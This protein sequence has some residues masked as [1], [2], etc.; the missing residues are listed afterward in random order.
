[1]MSVSIN[2]YLDSIN[3][4]TAAAQNIAIAGSTEQAGS[5]SSDKD[6]YIASGIDADSVLPSENYNNILDV[7]RSAKAEQT[8]SASDEDDTESVGSAGGSG[9][10]NSDD[11]DETTTKVVTINGETYLETTTVS[12]GVTTVTRTAIGA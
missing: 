3:A 4:I 5:V 10:G 11:E 6:S 2:D 1:M 12:N 8:A 9:G 7:M